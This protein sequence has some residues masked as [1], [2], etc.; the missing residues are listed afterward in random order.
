MTNEELDIRLKKIE[1]IHIWA[2][3]VLAFGIL[4]YF[5]IR[6]KKTA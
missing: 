6:N 1:N 2:I 5:G 3:P 4:I